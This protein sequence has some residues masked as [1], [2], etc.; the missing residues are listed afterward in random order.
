MALARSVQHS[1]SLVG[2]VALHD[3][4]GFPLDDSKDTS[5]IYARFCTEGLDGSPRLGGP[6]QRL[7]HEG[8]LERSPK[9]IVT[10]AARI[11]SWDSTCKPTQVGP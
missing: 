3:I 1:T 10:N 5:G 11:G 8:V 9:F 7:D 6:T 2:K 4:V